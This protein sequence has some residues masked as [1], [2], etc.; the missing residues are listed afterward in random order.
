MDFGGSIAGKLAVVANDTLTVHDHE[1]AL[2]LLT[3]DR[4][5]LRFWLVRQRERDL[6]L[7]VVALSLF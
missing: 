2:W 3:K 4:A 5:Q 6:G 7:V 1:R